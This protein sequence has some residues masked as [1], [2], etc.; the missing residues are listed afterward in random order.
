MSEVGPLCHSAS[1]VT[2]PAPGLGAEPLGVR[3]RARPA[4]MFRHPHPRAVG[5]VGARHRELLGGG[6]AQGGDMGAVCV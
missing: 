6:T 1:W 4:P 3:W 2:P 5:P